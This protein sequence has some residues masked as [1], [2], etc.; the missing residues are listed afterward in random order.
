MVNY[1]RVPTLISSI[2]KQICC[3]N[4][5]ST[6]LGRDMNIQYVLGMPNP[7]HH[8]FPYLLLTRA[9]QS[10]VAKV[11]GFVSDWFWH[12]GEASEVPYLAMGVA[13]GPGR[14]NMATMTWCGANI[15]GKQGG[16]GLLPSKSSM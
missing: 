15:L 9:T 13:P 1:Q 6:G 8:I 5:L 3:L 10:Q 2:S 7:F 12:T 14:V 4:V 11:K 16:K